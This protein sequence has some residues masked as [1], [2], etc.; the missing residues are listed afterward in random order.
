MAKKEDR[1]LLIELKTQ[2]DMVRSD[3]RELRDGFAQRVA[4]LEAQKLG[5]EEAQRLHTD[6]I[7]TT[8]DHETRLR[9]LERYGWMAIGILAAAEFA[10]KFFPLSNLFGG[11]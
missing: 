10:F 7:T 11:S 6:T 9:F 4:T 2:M 8:T 1:D 5:R 3:I